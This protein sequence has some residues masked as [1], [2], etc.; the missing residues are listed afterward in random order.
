MDMVRQF[1]STWNRPPTPRS[2]TGWSTPMSVMKS[3]YREGLSLGLDK[4]DAVIKRRVRQKY[5][6]IAEEGGRIR[7]DRCRSHGLSQGASGGVRSARRGQLRP[8]LLRSCEHQPRGVA[9]AKAALAKGANPAT[10]GQPSMLPRA[11]RQAVHSTWWRAILA[12][13]SPGRSATAPVGKWVG[14]LASGIGVHWFAVSARGAPQLAAARSSAHGR[15][16]R[17]GKRPANT[18]AGRRLPQ[19]CAPNM[20]SSSRQSYPRRR[21]P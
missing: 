8:G 20:M 18:L 1:Q 3:L 2:S 4:D 10:L 13:T 5:D 14:P 11:R 17:M 9:A 12:T 6:L 15:R 21:E 16:A 19:G 7:A